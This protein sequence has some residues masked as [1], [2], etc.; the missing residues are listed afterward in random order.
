MNK[1]APGALR[2]VPD[3]FNYQS[4]IGFRFYI[5]RLP[6][7][8]FYVQ[9]V[10]IPGVILPAAIEVTPFLDIPQPGD[11]VQ[12]E[13]LMLEFLVS[14]GLENY[15]E[16]QKWL[17]TIGDAAGG[18]AYAKLMNANPISGDGIRSEII[19]SVEDSAKNPVTNVVFH[20]A[21]PTSL[22]GLSFDST[23]VGDIKYLNATATFKYLNYSFD[24]DM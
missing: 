18:Q 19:L 15:V 1:T 17:L 24:N 20:D 22:T 21:W 8:N 13:P 9:K 16:L 2:N 11:H 14:E 4:P 23:E 10:N 3:T 7:V 5:K 12:Y 6:T